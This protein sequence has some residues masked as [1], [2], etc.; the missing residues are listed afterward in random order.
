MFRK[1]QPV[2][3]AEG[4][5]DRKEKRVTNKARLHLNAFV[6]NTLSTTSFDP[7]EVPSSENNLHAR[8]VVVDVWKKNWF[9]GTL[10]KT[11]EIYWN[12]ELHGLFDKGVKGEDPAELVFQSMN[13]QRL[14]YK[15]KLKKLRL[16]Q[17]RHVSHVMVLASTVTTLLS[18]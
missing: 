16:F 7:K 6:R 2:Y 10:I 8:R 14:A 13:N 12:K 4:K 1:K 3:T 15:S 17:P 5:F 18:P 11:D 9:Y